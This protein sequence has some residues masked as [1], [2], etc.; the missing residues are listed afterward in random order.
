MALREILVEL[1][2]K[3]DKKG[4]ATAQR[5]LDNLKKA[6]TAL[7]AVFATGALAKAFTGLTEELR[8][9]G[10]RIDKVSQ[11][12]GVNAQAL[13][14]LRFAA[15]QTGV[16]EENLNMALQ[17]FSR[18]SAEAAK[19]TGVALKTFQQLNIRLTDSAGK[20]R[21]VEDLLS[22]VSAGMQRTKDDS[23]RLRLAFTLFDSR[24]AALVNTLK[25]GPEVL[26]AY[27][28]QARELG[29]VMDDEMIKAAVELT[30][31]QSRLDL[32]LRG[33]KIVLGKEL[34]P[35]VTATTDFMTRFAKSARGPLRKGLDVLNDSIELMGTI[36]KG[37]FRPFSDFLRAMTESAKKATVLS[38]KLAEVVDVSKILTAL[39]AAL[40][41]AALAAGAKIVVAWLIAL[42]PALIFFALLAAV[43]VAIVAVAEDLIRMG[44]EGEGVFATLADGVQDLIDKHGDLGIA[45]GE[46]LDTALRAWLEF[47]GLT[48]DEA[49]EWI[50]NL[51][52]TLNDFWGTALEGVLGFFQRIDELALEFIKGFFDELGELGKVLLKLVGVGSE[53]EETGAARGPR[54]FRR[55]ADIVPQAVVPPAA[56]LPAGG[57]TS[58][59]NQPNNNTT[60]QVDATGANNPQAVGNAV[61]EVI[62]AEND[63]Q[64]RQ[65]IKA[66]QVI[67]AGA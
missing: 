28:Q 35:V 40:G 60:V 16:A 5:G 54:T 67:G 15:D 31:A 38:D 33:V 36:I 41:L 18:R 22:D 30:D 29:G 10:D 47:F 37:A 56:A 45:I 48:S 55:I 42:A 57:G 3:V 49:D 13:Q 32:A 34:L 1:G 39:F 14:E 50:D 63:R 65:T 26:A 12:I 6:A 64:L 53:D 23:E 58:M 66:F 46:V 7:A 52:D 21:P 19:G 8:V 17:R 24:G 51:T 43:G 25:E 4:Q 9:A 11:K 59:I 2:F 27:R 20:L 61:Q 44:T 62:R